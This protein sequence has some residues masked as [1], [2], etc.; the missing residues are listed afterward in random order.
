MPKNK[1]PITF[2]FFFLTKQYMAKRIVLPNK[3]QKKGIGHRG[4][5]GWGR[6][7]NGRSRNLNRS[8][9]RGR[10]RSRN[11]NR[12][13][14]GRNHSINRRRNRSPRG[15][16]RSL[17]RRNIS[18]SPRGRNRSLGRRNRSRSPRGR[19]RSL[20]RRNRSPVRRSR[21]PVRRSRSP[22]R[23]NRSPVRRS[24]SPVRRSRSP[25]RPIIPPAIA[26]L[27]E[28][29]QR[30]LN[31][32]LR[33]D[34]T[35]RI[36]FNCLNSLHVDQ[37]YFERTLASLDIVERHFIE[38]KRSDAIREIKDRIAGGDRSITILVLDCENILYRMS[39][40]GIVERRQ[41]IR[42]ITAEEISN[43]SYTFAVFKSPESLRTITEIDERFKV[44]NFKGFS[45]MGQPIGSHGG[46]DIMAFL[47]WAYI[48]KNFDFK[49]I[50]NNLR[51][52]YA[53]ADNTVVLGTR[54][55]MI[56]LSIINF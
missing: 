10:E 50:K 26:D 18:R 55:N 53:P 21:S 38:L 22:V 29:I 25:V 28:K 44:T 45:F 30:K 46:D 8:H 19:N 13:R 48:S 16:S 52:Q 42:K 24:R 49:K 17:A 31:F 7:R 35:F 41:G 39:R 4:Y 36:N 34:E 11:H 20:G 43:Y 14:R 6:I 12:S 5:N 23:R 32:I 3:T 37:G 27:C 47:I 2:K 51:S 33:D 15:R 54:D 9:L 56:E 40:Q 1:C